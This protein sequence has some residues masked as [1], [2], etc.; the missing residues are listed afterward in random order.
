MT[1]IPPEGWQPGEAEA[2]G[3][4]FSRRTLGLDLHSPSTPP[5]PPR[6][7]LVVPGG[8]PMGTG[9]CPTLCQEESAGLPSW[10]KRHPSVCKL[11]LDVTWRGFLL[12][13]ASVH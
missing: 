3:S 11:D 13:L 6:G 1:Q 2:G 8:A 10:P 9:V 12:V 5:P 4:V 7:S